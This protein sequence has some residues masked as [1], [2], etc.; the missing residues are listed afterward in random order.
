VLVNQQLNDGQWVSVGVYPFATGTS[1]SVTI[2][3]TSTAQGTY[4]M[5]DAV[6]L[7]PVGD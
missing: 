2:S 4:V 3:N 6:R 5:A 1:G 7:V